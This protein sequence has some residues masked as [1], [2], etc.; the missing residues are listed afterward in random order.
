LPL[1]AHARS[2]SSRFP[3]GLY[4]RQEQSDQDP[5]DRDDDEEFDQGE[6]T[7]AGRLF[8]VDHRRGPMIEKEVAQKNRLKSYYQKSQVDQFRFRKNIAKR[9]GV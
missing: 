5:D 9:I 2:A 8:A 7:L 3:C 1:V 6:A 4:G